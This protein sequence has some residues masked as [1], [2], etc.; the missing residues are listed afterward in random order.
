MA[1]QEHRPQRS[2]DGHRPAGVW[3]A[4]REHCGLLAATWS[5]RRL[6]RREFALVHDMASVVRAVEAKRGRPVVITEA[7]LPSEVSAF[8]MHGRDQDHIV[9]DV[10]SSELTKMHSML[11][12]VCHLMDGEPSE[13]EGQPMD[14]EAVRRILPGLKP[15]GV[16]RV[17]NRSHYDRACERRAE[18]FATEMLQRLH[19][20]RSGGHDVMCSAF[21]H[22][23]AGV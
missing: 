19:L 2:T 14:E 22:R 16:L 23:S 7:A 6:V 17:L 8:C 18:A 1:L 9:V 10:W 20:G 11:H 15:A 3:Q 4:L 12:E 5:A 21:S 13:E